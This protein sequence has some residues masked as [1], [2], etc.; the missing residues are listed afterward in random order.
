MK[1]KILRE[2]KEIELFT[3][4]NGRQENRY[5]D[6][7][8]VLYTGSTKD[9]CIGGLLQNKRDAVE[10][11]TNIRNISHERTSQTMPKTD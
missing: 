11:V 9:F 10:R 2:R 7:F 4:E 5:C 1:K 3:L 8:R 6:S